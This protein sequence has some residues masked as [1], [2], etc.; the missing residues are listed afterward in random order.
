MQGEAHQRARIAQVQETAQAQPRKRRAAGRGSLLLQAI[1]RCG[2]GRQSGRR[3]DWD[4]RGRRRNRSAPPGLLHLFKG[5][6]GVLK[7]DV[8]AACSAQDGQQLRGQPW[9]IQGAQGAG[10][11]RQGAG[12]AEQGST[13]LPLLDEIAR[14][15]ADV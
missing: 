6:K 13:G 1:R 2:R 10:G 8:D 9:P 14:H 11:R 7:R 4:G 12:R 5:E 15:S 3:R